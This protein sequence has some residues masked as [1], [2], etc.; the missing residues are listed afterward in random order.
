MALEILAFRSESRLTYPALSNPVNTARRL[1]AR[2]IV[3]RPLTSLDQ[4]TVLIIRIHALKLDHTCSL[5][6]R[7]DQKKK[8]GSHLHLYPRRYVPRLL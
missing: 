2:P 8:K 4:P 5:G 3:V 1:K 7:V 6:C